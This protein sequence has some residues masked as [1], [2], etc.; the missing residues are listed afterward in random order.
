[1]NLDLLL[2]I[3][4]Y[5]LLI[6]YIVTHKSRFHFQGKIF[7][8]YKTK[9]GL[10]LMDKIPKRFPRLFHHMGALSIFI[11]FVGMGFIFYWLLKG[12]FDLILVAGTTPSVAPI[13]PGIKVI[14][15]LPILS[16]LHWIFAILVIALI[17]EFSHGI[18]ARLYNIK[19]KSSGFALFGPILAAFV[20]P[21]EKQLEKKSKRIQLSVFSAGPFSNIITGFLFLGILSF[22]TAPIYATTFDGDGVIV[23]DLIEDFPMENTGVEIPFTIKGLNGYEVLDF[24]DFTNATRDITPGDEVTLNTNKGEFSII[25]AVNPDNES[26]GFM[27]IS[28][29]ELARIPNKEI[30][31]KYGNFIPPLVQ[32]IHLF[33]FWLWVISWG[34]GLFNLLPLGPIDGGRMLLS[35]LLVITKNKERAH[36]YWSVASMVCLLLIF[37]NLAPYL[38]KL[39]LFIL[40][41]L[42]FLLTLG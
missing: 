29:F 13:L 30:A 21:D 31:E 2:A 12:T 8:L 27:G 1:M 17:H 19:V 42:L 14:P 6:R 32:W 16:F 24:Q 41:P 9:L 38:W 3:I 37:I 39:L 40:K 26:K 34:V 28:N 35:G 22:V 36:K 33:I 15:G 18:Y 11:G 20:E 23:N 7:A 10:K 5:A 4:F 25:A